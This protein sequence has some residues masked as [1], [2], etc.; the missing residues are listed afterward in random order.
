M[1]G[2]LKEAAEAIQLEFERFRNRQFLEAVMA[3]SALVATADGEVRFAE[4]HMIDEVLETVQALRIYDPHQA[5]DI[6]RDHVTALHDQPALGYERA[7]RAIRRIADEPDAARILVKVSLA[8]GKSND[9]F[10]D[11]ERAVIGIICDTLGVD[12]AEAGL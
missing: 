3:A 10:K 9:E 12:R 2:F 6:Y 8:I 7:I 11:A 1:T 4:L 5:V